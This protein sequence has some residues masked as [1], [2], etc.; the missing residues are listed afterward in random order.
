MSSPDTLPELIASLTHLTQMQIVCGYW[1]PAVICLI[2][3]GFETRSMLREDLKG[4]DDE[5]YTA[6]MTFG[7]LVF[8]AVVSLTPVL[9]IVKAAVTT[10]LPAGVM[11]VLLTIEALNKPMI[12]RKPK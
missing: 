10:V 11:L 6:Q 5:S 4:R 12:S 7:T 8:Q 3:Y 1:V 9:N 2:R